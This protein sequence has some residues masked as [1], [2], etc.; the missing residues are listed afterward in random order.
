MAGASPSCGFDTGES[1]VE[2]VREL[3]E[4]GEIKPGRLNDPEQPGSDVGGA[5]ERE[6]EPSPEGEPAGP[7]ET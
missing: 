6:Q 4:A 7:R 3:R 2:G 1:Q 5:S